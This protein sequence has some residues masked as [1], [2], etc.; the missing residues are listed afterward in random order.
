MLFLFTF[1]GRISGLYES[2][3]VLIVV[4][5]RY[6][7]KRS[8]SSRFP[9]NTITQLVARDDMISLAYKSVV[10]T[11]TCRYARHFLTD[12]FHRFGNKKNPK[13]FFFISGAFLI[14]YFFFM[15]VAGIPLYFLEL[16]L[17]QF[18]GLSPT[19]L[20]NISPLFKGEPYCL[21]YNMYS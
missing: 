2:V 17:G 18:S 19:A 8:T 20:W 16:S 15:F 7:L 12:L 9:Y 6:L 1:V 11:S 3:V 14:P 21:N 10:N 4:Y 5:F 13:K